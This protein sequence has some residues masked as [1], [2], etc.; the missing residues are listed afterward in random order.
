[1][2]KASKDEQKKKLRSAYL[3]KRNNMEPEKRG[4]AS[5]KIKEWVFANKRVKAAKILFV[6]DSYKSEV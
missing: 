5:K 3:E 6:Y 4:A 2:S 1:M